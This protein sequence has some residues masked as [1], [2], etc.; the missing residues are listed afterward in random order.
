MFD[1]SFIEKIVDLAKPEIV[2]DNYGRIYGSG[3]LGK[4]IETPRTPAVTVDTL[5]G[6]VSFINDIEENPEE[7][8]VL[9]EDPWT[10]SVL[11]KKPEGPNKRRSLLFEIQVIHFLVVP[12]QRRPQHPARLHVPHNDRVI[13]SGGGDHCAVRAHGHQQNTAFMAA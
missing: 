6:L 12:Q 7:S 10:V 3:T 8:F 5:T 2:T 13:L 9:I 4:E 11:S 1:R